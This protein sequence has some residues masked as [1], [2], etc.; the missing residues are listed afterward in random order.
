MVLS[1]S[2]MRQIKRDKTI[3]VKP[4]LTTQNLFAAAL[5]VRQRNGARLKYGSFVVATPLCA[6]SLAKGIYNA[7]KGIV[8]DVCSLVPFSGIITITT[9]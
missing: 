2:K 5:H 1:Q 8:F 4:A 3:E 6:L 7:P 9:K